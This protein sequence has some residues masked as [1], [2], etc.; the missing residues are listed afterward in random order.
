MNCEIINSPEHFS[1]MLCAEFLSYIFEKIIT[2]MYFLIVNYVEID[3]CSYMAS[4]I[5]F[6]F[7]SVT[8]FL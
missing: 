5:Y 2:G 7:V 8:H 1:V 6:Q 3:H 4:G